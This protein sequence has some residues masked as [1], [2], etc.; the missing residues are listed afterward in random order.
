MN[1]IKLTLLALAALLVGGCVSAP[2]R[3]VVV[4][5]SGPQPQVIYIREYP[6]PYY[7]P[8]PVFSFRFGYGYGRGW[9]R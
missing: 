1:K 6:Y 2:T 3:T 7:N 8:Y 9:R 5:E 4:P